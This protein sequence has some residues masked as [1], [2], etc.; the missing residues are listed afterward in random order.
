MTFFARYVIIIS[1][2]KYEIL[3]AILLEL[4]QKR[5]VNAAYLAAKYGV[6]ERTVYR[7]VSLLSSQAPV[8]V[9]RGRGGGVRISDAFKLPVGFLTE[10]E[11]DAATEALEGAY[12]HTADE[13]FLRARRKLTE[14]T[15][16]T[17]ETEEA[18]PFA[19]E[20][21][22]FRGGLGGEEMQAKL[23]LMQECIREH[24]V[25]EIDYREKKP[26]KKTRKIEPHLIVFEGETPFVYAFCRQRKDFRLFALGKIYTAFSL[27]EKFIPREFSQEDIP[28]GGAAVEVRLEIDD[29]AL[30]AVAECVGGQKIKER[31]GKKTVELL[32]PD[33]ER[34]PKRL[35]ALGAGVTVVKPE[36]I[37]KKVRALITGILK[38]YSSP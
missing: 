6:S 22:L 28:V 15:K 3:I 14:A 2:M 33:D 13:R 10:E 21:A 12:A 32:L 5:Q 1:P 27:D 23:R 16:Q 26:S 7:Y 25:L 18:L 17:E 35:L 29:F 9:V 8:E 19:E 31:A 38:S 20:L 11:Y 37:K 24:T 36:R 34:L 30:S 4:L